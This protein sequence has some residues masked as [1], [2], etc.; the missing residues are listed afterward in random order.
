M[1]NPFDTH[2]IR[3][4]AQGGD[5]TLDRAAELF[6]TIYMPSRNLTAGSRKMYK[7]DVAYLVAFLKAQGVHHPAAVNLRALQIYLARLDERKLSGATRRRKVA[8]IKTFFHFLMTSEY[9]RRDPSRE[10]VPPQREYREPRFLSR[11]EYQALLRACSQDPRG[12]A[13]IELI[14]QTGIK[15]SEMAQLTTSDVQLPARIDREPENTGSL[16][17]H[18]KGRKNRIVP[19]NYK[20][21]QALKRWLSVR[22]EAETSSLFVTK[23]RLP[24]GPRTIQN[25]VF[26]YRKA[27][28]IKGARVY[29]LRH[30]FA[31]Y[32]LANGMAL[33]SLQ[34]ML[35]YESLETTANYTAASQKL[36]RQMQDN[37]L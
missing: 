22:P 29:T 10:L 25:I 6:A 11:A 5:L 7:I 4:E 26:K 14:L 24:L 37:A 34:E 3:E 27:A 9:I 13:I 35:G 12:A 20:A 30:T 16:T 8:V 17:I 32:Q 31:T 18:G 2:T 15:L 33:R 28:G 36:R 19:L 23:F 21:C 1:W